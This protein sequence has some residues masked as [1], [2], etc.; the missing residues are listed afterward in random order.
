MTESNAP[1][2]S[3]RLCHPLPRVLISFS[4]IRGV[5]L[6]TQLHPIATV[7]HPLPRVLI[8]AGVTARG[9]FHP[10]HLR[11]QPLFT[12]RSAH[13]SLLALRVLHYPSQTDSSLRAQRV[14]H[15]HVECLK[16]LHSLLSTFNIKHSKFK[17]PPPISRW[18]QFDNY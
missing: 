17:P 18:R 13:S 10:I 8:M 1:N 11:R 2:E 16:W 15:S 12:M 9:R 3:Q 7:C 14:F 5:T 4:I 6:L